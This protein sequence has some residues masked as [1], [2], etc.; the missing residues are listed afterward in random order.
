MALPQR[1][2]SGTYHRIFIRIL[3]SLKQQ[4]IRKGSP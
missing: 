4:C 3:I 2:T 1:L